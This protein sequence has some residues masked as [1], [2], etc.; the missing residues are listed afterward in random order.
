MVPGFGSPIRQPMAS[1]NARL[2]GAPIGEVAISRDCERDIA[3]V[4]AGTPS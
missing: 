2:A 1:E 4:S 3:V